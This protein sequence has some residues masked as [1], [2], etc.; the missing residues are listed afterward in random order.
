MAFDNTDNTDMPCDLW[1]EQGTKDYYK[2]L[3]NYLFI[4]SYLINFNRGTKFDKILDTAK[5]SIEVV[6]SRTEYFT[7]QVE[8]MYK[9]IL[10]A[11]LFI[12]IESIEKN[13]MSNMYNIMDMI[14]FIC[15]NIQTLS[16][17]NARRDYL[18]KYSAELTTLA[19]IAKVKIDE[20]IVLNNNIIQL[21]NDA[22][23]K[24]KNAYIAV[25]AVKVLNIESKQATELSDKIVEVADI[26][27]K[28]FT[29]LFMYNL[30]EGQSNDNTMYYLDTIDVM[31]MICQEQ[32]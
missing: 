2:V 8:Y 27:N 5:T 24:E 30:Q 17:N 13:N 20:A 7:T 31:M 14:N 11:L 3:T 32:T 9:C 23:I 16:P 4:K 10:H 18:L 6:D 21:I 1:A 19:S 26:A 29:A 22:Y 28:F 12:L 25:K 15:N